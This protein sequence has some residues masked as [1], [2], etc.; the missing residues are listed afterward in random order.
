[1]IENYKSA[2]S[3]FKTPEI[4]ENSFK[5]LQDIMIDNKELTSYVNYKD[6]IY[7]VN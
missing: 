6:L 3:W 2:D 7:E 4:S 5:N 1:M